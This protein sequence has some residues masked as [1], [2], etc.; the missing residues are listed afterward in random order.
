MTVLDA[1]NAGG[2]TVWPFLGV[3]VFPEKGSGIWWF[4]TMSD[5]V[6]DV[7]TK[8]AACPVLLGQKWSKNHT[9][10]IVSLIN[11]VK[12]MCISVGNKWISYK[13]QS[14]KRPCHL[15][16]EQRFVGVLPKKNRYL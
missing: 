4:N 7:V 12:S 16:P 11:A 13:A 14:E 6:P 3:Y 2:A 15:K 5:S 9:I 1:P 10:Q 8:H